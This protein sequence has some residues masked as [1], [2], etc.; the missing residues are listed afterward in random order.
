MTISYNWLNDYLP[1]VI[2]PEK[3]SKILTSIGLEVESLEKFEAVKGAF[4]GLIIAEVLECEKHPNADKLSITKVNI[5]EGEPLQIVCGASNVA[6]GQKV[7]VATIGTTIYP[8]NGEPLTMKIV[9]I[10]GTESYGM[11]CAEDEIGLSDNHDGILVL[12][13]DVAIGTKASDYFDTNS[14]WIFEI[15]LTPNRMDAMS[16]LG[17]AKD[18]CAFLSHHNKINTRVKSPFTNNISFSAT[19]N[20][21]NVIIENSNDCKRYAGLKINNVTITDSPKWLK[22]KL[23][24]IGVKSI[25]NLVDITNFILH[26]TGQPLHAFDCNAIAEN[27]I[28][29][30]NLNADS[31]FTTLDE[32]ERKLLA[33]D[34]II[35]D[36]NKNPMCIAGVYGG[37]QS[38]VTDL[39][40]SIFL[41]SAFFSSSSIRKTSLHHQLRTD[42]ATRFE[43]GV[44]IS[45]TVNVLKRAAQL[46]IKVCGGEIIGELIDVYPEPQEKKSIVLKYHYLKK[47]SGKNYHPDAV[48]RILEAL[49][50]EI[51]RTGIDNIQV[52]VP[53]AKT[54]IS[55]PA[56]LV[57]EIIRIDGL[58]NIEIP[59]S[60]NLTPAI[61]Q[62]K[63]KENLLQ[64]IGSFLVGQGFNE[65]I[66]NSITN[67]NY[68]DAEVMQHSVKMLNNLT[69]ELDVMQSGLLESGLET[70]SFN[71]NRKNNNLQL[72]EFG[73]SYHQ[74]V[75]HK[76]E[77][78]EH[79]A[80]FL[81][82]N[83]IEDNWNEKNKSNDYFR[84]KGM[85]QSVLQVCGIHSFK[86]EQDK[87]N[88][89]VLHIL[90]N[91]Q[92]LGSIALVL[93]KKLT[94]FDIKQPVFYIDFNFNSLLE[95]NKNNVITYK[96]IGKYPSVQR[97]LSLVIDKDINFEKVENVTN[98]INLTS[99]KNIQLFDVF[100]SEKLG[101]NKKSIA[102]SFTF[103]NE[104]KT[105]TDK[106]IDEAMNKL[107]KSF[108][109]ELEAEVRKS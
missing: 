101:T 26:E 79:L 78:V 58:D 64:K 48:I 14:D 10:R 6:K 46:I 15:G 108:E 43:K 19:K 12:P 77:E 76:F 106:E 73:K 92:K 23:Q 85:I 16:H 102:L 33:S 13:N 96:E 59:N 105:L 44:D 2:E 36:G 74:Y 95:F 30:T 68:F 54:D 17:V 37:L 41:E 89:E 9:K 82:G 107:V 47:L 52:A 51:E 70:I 66:T 94:Q 7:V 56:D 75:E 45:N 18:V 5:G 39:T 83:Y 88:N 38:G 34:L 84:A 49:G 50:F 71:L 3:L 98:K 63:F 104:E 31:S 8:K 109:K 87:K 100:E 29:V 4:E 35:C 103:T 81:T 65:I 27:T 57:E 28:I 60:I 24:S 90:F 22:N 40:K 93:K 91:K 53:F 61:N 62:F 42:A 32:K 25:N 67:S 21:I 69:V 80:L 20:P 72:F 11:I 99:L 1:E 55:I 86:L 97:D